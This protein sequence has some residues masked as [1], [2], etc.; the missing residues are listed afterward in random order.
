MQNSDSIF[1]VPVANG[2]TSVKKS[3]KDHS[4]RRK[5]RERQACSDVWL[6]KQ[7]VSI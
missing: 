4:R 6:T 7:T 1:I 5:M 3:L 2:E